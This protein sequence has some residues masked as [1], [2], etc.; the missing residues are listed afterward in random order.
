MG[1][2]LDSGVNLRVIW[3]VL[4]ALATAEEQGGL[5]LLVLYRKSLRYL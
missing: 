4:N 5:M 1:K 3:T 2:V